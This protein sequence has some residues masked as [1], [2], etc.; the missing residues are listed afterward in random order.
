MI[1]E[2]RPCPPLDSTRTLQSRIQVPS[3]LIAQMN[4]KSNRARKSVRH[5]DQTTVEKSEDL[6]PT[7]LRDSRLPL[8]VIPRRSHAPSALRPERPMRTQT[9]REGQVVESQ[10]P[11]SSSRDVKLVTHVMEQRPRVECATA[12]HPAV[13][14]SAASFRLCGQ[15][16]EQPT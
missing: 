9:K 2:H 8:P 12:H 15:P 6:Q 16:Q 1:F 7:A 11:D 14:M 10:P 3:F 4:L 13:E 5:N